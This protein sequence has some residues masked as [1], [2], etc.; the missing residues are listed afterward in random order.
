MTS[1]GENQNLSSSPRESSIIKELQNLYV[2]L[3]FVKTS[4]Y[5]KAWVEQ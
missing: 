1:D 4:R 3:L 5:N 2:W